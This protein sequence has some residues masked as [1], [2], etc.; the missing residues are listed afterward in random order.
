M[1]YACDRSHNGLHSRSWR[2]VERASVASVGWGPGP[3]MF[4]CREGTIGHRVP[5][6]VS[7]RL[8]SSG[9]AVGVIFVWPLPELGI[10][11]RFAKNWP[12]RGFILFLELLSQRLRYCGAADSSHRMATTARVGRDNR[13]RTLIFPHVPGSKRS[14]VQTSFTVRPQTSAT[15]WSCRSTF[16]AGA[17][18]QGSRRAALWERHES[19][20]SG[21]SISWS[22]LPDALGMRAAR[23]L[24]STL[25]SGSQVCTTGGGNRGNAQAARRECRHH[26]PI[27]R[28]H[29][30]PEGHG[31]PSCGAAAATGR[32]ERRGNTRKAGTTSSGGGSS[33]RQ[34]MAISTGRMRLE[35]F[36]VS[37]CPDQEI[38]NADL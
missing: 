31:E 19:W 10:A 38:R 4:D 5:S 24:E 1:Y 18:M 7:A 2:R 30:Q 26:R 14:G 37:G 25:A 29:G 23:P 34:N 3:S 32:T 9:A 16:S 8:G 6:V 36:T 20:S 15:C 27:V 33:T 17:R 28:Q 12:Q 11:A 21:S 22:E 35:S 13:P